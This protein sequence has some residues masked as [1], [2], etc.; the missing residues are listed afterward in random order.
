MRQ[1][2]YN[3][4]YKRRIDSIMTQVEANHNTLFENLR[5][6][7]NNHSNPLISGNIESQM[8]LI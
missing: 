3:T 7:R 1:K 2:L 8:W 4:G 6:V 5:S